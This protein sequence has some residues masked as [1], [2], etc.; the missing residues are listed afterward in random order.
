MHCPS[1]SLDFQSVHEVDASHK[2]EEASDKVEQVDDVVCVPKS[3]KSIGAGMIH[4]AS[5]SMG[6][7]K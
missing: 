1:R 3:H 4:T 2:V 6:S 7:I 5:G